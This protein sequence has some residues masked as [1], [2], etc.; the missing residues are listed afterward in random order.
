[1]DYGLEK[2]SM[3]DRKLR[4]GIVFVETGYNP[5]DIASKILQLVEEHIITDFLIF[6]FGYVYPTHLDLSW[7]PNCITS[8]TFKQTYQLHPKLNEITYPPHIT[9]IDECEE[10]EV[11]VGGALTYDNLQI[12]SKLQNIDWPINLTSLSIAYITIINVKTLNNLPP[13]LTD[14]VIGTIEV[15]GDIIFNELFA[16][17]IPS[18]LKNINFR[19]IKDNFTIYLESYVDHRLHIKLDCIATDK[20]LTLEYGN[21]RRYNIS[22]AY[23]FADS[24]HYHSYY[25]YYNHIYLDENARPFPQSRL[26]INYNPNYDIIESPRK[27]AIQYD[28]AYSNPVNVPNLHPFEYLENERKKYENLISKCEKSKL[29]LL[30]S[31][32]VGDIF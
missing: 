32:F 27:T 5:I 12:L 24:I 20:T 13:F 4:A 26:V 30:D 15:Y 11:F 21:R 1:M 16:D 31:Q 19:E 25:P 9:R 18:T 22:L 29:E 8:I 2:Q 14:L 6:E 28:F 7:I 3:H 17:G 10:I 23:H